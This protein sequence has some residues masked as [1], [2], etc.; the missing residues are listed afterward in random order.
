MSGPLIQNREH[1]LHAFASEAAPR[2]EAEGAP[3]PQKLRISVG[4][5]SRG[6]TGARRP[7][8]GECWYPEA[9]TDGHT[10]IFISPTHASER[11]AASTL[12]HELVHAA[13]P[14]AGHGPAFKRLGKALGL[15]GKP[16]EMQGGPDWER[17]ALPILER[18]G[19][20][21]AARL[22]PSS[23]PKQSTRL[24][25]VVCRRCGFTFRASSKWTEG[26]VMVCPDLMCGGPA[27]LTHGDKP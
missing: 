4:W 5:P 15:E 7:V 18:L 27:L 13:Q 1:W 10:E 19:P 25:K 12:T 17:W 21:P 2:F 16:T 14:D 11:D 6:G 24:L 3:L 23:R 8:I 22:N 20:M 9:S 26:K